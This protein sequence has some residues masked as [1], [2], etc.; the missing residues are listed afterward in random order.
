MQFL[1]LFSLWR[2]PFHVGMHRRS[3]QPVCVVRVKSRCAGV[4]GSRDDAIRSRPMLIRNAIITSHKP[5]S[6]A[7][8]MMSSAAFLARTESQP[9]PDC[10]ESWR[11]PKAKTSQGS[12]RRSIFSCTVLFDLEMGNAAFESRQRRCRSQRSRE[13]Q[14]TAT[15]VLSRKRQDAGSI[16]LCRFR[17]ADTMPKSR[18]PT[19]FEI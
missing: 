16:I 15:H 18:W 2:S 7:S 12:N 1:L 9:H 6:K 4:G 11:S 3:N 19:S 17:A 8:D 10:L 14:V 13:D 5:D